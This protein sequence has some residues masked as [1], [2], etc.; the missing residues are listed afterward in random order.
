MSKAGYEGCVYQGLE[1]AQKRIAEL[2]AQLAKANVCEVCGDCLE[3][4][5]VRCERHVNTERG[6]PEWTYEPE[7]TGEAEWYPADYDA[8]EQAY[9]RS[10]PTISA[11]T[12]GIYAALDAVKYRLRTDTAIAKADE[13]NAEM[14][15]RLVDAE[16]EREELRARFAKV[17]EWAR[18][19]SCRTPRAV[20]DLL[21]ILGDERAIALRARAQPDQDL[22]S[23]KTS[24]TPFEVLLARSS[25]GTP[26]VQAI[27]NQTSPETVDKILARADEL[28]GVSAAHAAVERAVQHADG[29]AKAED[30]ELG[31]G[32]WDDEACDHLYDERE[33]LGSETYALACALLR[34]AREKKL[35]EPKR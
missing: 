12:M 9:T 6:D 18:G 15:G 21:V 25:L 23:G 14:F 30:W 31:G 33:T 5:P 3:P 13:R 17:R 35:K 20:L 29:L 11:T 1:T 22:L 24:E 16:E 4:V 19:H 34:E 8:A 26:E 7:Q 32:F 10:H 27:R 2:E 28:A